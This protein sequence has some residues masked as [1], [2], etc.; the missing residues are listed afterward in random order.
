[1]QPAADAI[2]AEHGSV[3]IEADA[4]T[5]YSM[6]S[7]IDRMGE[8]SPEATGGRWLDGGGPSVGSWFEGDNR[9]GEREWS[10]QCQV[11]EAE[12]GRAFT[13]VIDGMEANCTWWSYELEPTA[14]GTTVTE[15]WWMV[16]K[17]PGMQA[18][19]P[20]QIA[21]RIEYTRATLI[22][23]TLAAL[24]TAAEQAS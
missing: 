3:E 10:R 8:W 16:N 23:G 21:K 22:P 4:D 5:L 7:A 20:E 15:Y 18:A 1:M 2:A 11:A 6:V 14:T 13:F 12:P 17:T 24:K 19:T 9:D